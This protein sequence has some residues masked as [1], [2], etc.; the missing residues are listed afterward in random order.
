MQISAVQPL[1]S[2]ALRVGP[3]D[4]AEPKVWT[5]LWK[6]NPQGQNTLDRLTRCVRCALALSKESPENPAAP[7]R[8]GS[9][10]FWLRLASTKTPWVSM[11]QLA[12]QL[13]GCSEELGKQ[14]I[15]QVA[16]KVVS[17]TRW[18][19]L[20]NRNS[21]GKYYQNN[22]LKLTQ[23]DGCVMVLEILKQLAI[24]QNI[25]HQNT[26][27]IPHYISLFVETPS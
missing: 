3:L 20:L 23:V 12:S 14:T 1:F 24:S 15:L 22:P 7:G 10:A 16:I 25:C 13:E 21:Y 8:F 18:W 5:C 11:C 17:S 19:T 9:L 4:T 2:W 26:E 27:I 6:F